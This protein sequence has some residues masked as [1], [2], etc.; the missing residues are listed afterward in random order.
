MDVAA[1]NQPQK[2]SALTRYTALL[3]MSFMGFGNQ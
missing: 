3:F 1:N 2:T